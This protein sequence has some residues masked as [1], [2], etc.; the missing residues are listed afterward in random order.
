MLLLGSIKLLERGEPDV[1]VSV[2]SAGVLVN[3]IGSGVG[4][5][6]VSGVDKDLTSNNKIIER[7][8]KIFKLSTA[9]NFQFEPSF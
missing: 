3:F 5:S 8:F 9:K 4:L 2:V 6:V 7:N 1:F